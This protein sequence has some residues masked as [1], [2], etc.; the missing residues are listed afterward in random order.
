MKRSVCAVIVTYNRMDVLK[1]ALDHIFAQT[2][3]PAT[4]I[5]VDNNSS[6][7]TRSYLNTFKNNKQVKSLLLENNIGYAGGI[8][9]GIL[10]ALSFSK[11]DYFWIMD[12][13]SFH[14]K[15]T[16]EELI[17]NIEKTDY[18]MIGLS[19]FNI[20][21]GN[22]VKSKSPAKLHD[23]D[24]A[25]IDGALVR[26]EAI[27][28][29]GVP[30]EKF[31]MM[32]ED[33]EYCFRLKRADLKIGVLNLGSTERLYLG[34]GGRFTKSTL[35][36]GYYQSRNHIL[37]L[38]EY[39]SFMNLFGFILK[40]IKMIIAAAV[41]A[42]DRVKRV[43]LRLLGIYHGLKGVEGKTLDPASMQFLYNR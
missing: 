13:D 12:D 30:S 1:K 18:S 35:W 21:L 5:I 32:C 40:Q 29:V 28:K 42:P 8:A 41:F 27:Q 39:F 43:K 24:Y 31:F 25:L 22:K 3:Q 2:I 23:I 16:L 26:A 17:V 6:D 14:A 36:R 15:N 9:Q 19:G 10:Y 11:Y 37:I 7:G 33:H 38:R 4:V 34:G 20:R